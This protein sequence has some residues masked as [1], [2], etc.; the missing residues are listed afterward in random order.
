MKLAIQRILRMSEMKLSLEDDVLVFEYVSAHGEKWQGCIG[1]WIGNQEGSASVEDIQAEFE[2][3]GYFEVGACG[4]ADK[5]LVR[6]DERGTI[7]YYNDFDQTISE[8]APDL[9]EFL[10]RLRVPTEDE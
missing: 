7:C 3:S 2:A 5:V 9:D 6:D 10:L 1:E 4:G 8:I